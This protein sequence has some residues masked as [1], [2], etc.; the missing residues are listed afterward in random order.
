MDSLTENIVLTASKMFNQFGIR[1]VS[2]DDICNELHISKKTFYN[3]FPQKENLVRMVLDFQIKLKEENLEKIYK[4]K[5]AIDSL[6]IVIRELKNNADKDPSAF[7]YDLKKYYPKIYSKFKEERAIR[8][9][10]NFE[11][12]LRQGIEE[13]YYRQDLDI[14]LISLFH[15]IQIQYSFEEM[16]KI[17]P[18]INRK[19]LTDFFIDLVVTLITNENG[20]KYINENNKKT[21]N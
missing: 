16:R 4:N 11:K 6:I 8:I 19:R 21:E 12:N 9:R 13:G 5:N 3:I 17:S 1:R 10:H 15:S 20:L 7:F 2:I 14:E 18:K